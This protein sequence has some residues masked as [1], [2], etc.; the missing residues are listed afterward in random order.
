MTMRLGV[1]VGLFATIPMLRDE[2]LAAYPH[3]KLHKVNRVVDEAETIDCLQVRY[4]QHRP[5]RQPRVLDALLY[6]NGRSR[7]PERSI[8]WRN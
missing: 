7:F 5:F 6:R 8:A 3:A 2:L 4:R 1:A